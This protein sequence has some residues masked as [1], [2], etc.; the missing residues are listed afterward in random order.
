M[1][2]LR[3]PRLSRLDAFRVEVMHKIGVLDLELKA[4]N[5]HGELPV[6]AVLDDEPIS[7]MLRRVAAVGGNATVFARGEHVRV[8]TFTNVAD[9]LD[10][11]AGEDMASDGNRP[12]ATAAVGAFLDYL[13]L[14]HAGVRV[15]LGPHSTQRSEA[16]G[17][18]DVPAFL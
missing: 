5:E 7:V 15:A 6:V 1:R 8:V 11:E 13:E 9:A 2:L 17:V 14:R 16:S 4:T 12:G 10:P 3:R 18:R